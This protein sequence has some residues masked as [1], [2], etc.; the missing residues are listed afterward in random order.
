[1]EPRANLKPHNRL[2]LR[3]ALLLLLLQVAGECAQLEQRL[4]IP[5]KR[6]NFSFIVVS[7]RLVSKR[8]RICT[9][10]EASVPS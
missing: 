4:M 5:E 2:Q 3:A 1:M 10:S 8:G 6:S 7:Q 9:L